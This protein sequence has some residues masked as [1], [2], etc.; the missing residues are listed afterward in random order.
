MLRPAHSR[1]GLVTFVATKVTKK[2]VSRNASLQ[3]R[4]FALQISQNRGLQNIAPL[5][6]HQADA[7]A[8]IAM[9]FPT[10]KATIVLPDFVRSCSADG[11]NFKFIGSINEPK[12]ERALGRQK[13]GPGVW[14]E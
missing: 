13:S 8:T 12:N 7:S 5:R 4:A 3:H 6:S 10:H 9:P 1:G 11:E 2:A 14:R